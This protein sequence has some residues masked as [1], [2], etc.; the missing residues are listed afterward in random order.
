MVISLLFLFLFLKTPIIMVWLLK[1]AGENACRISLVTVVVYSMYVFS[2][3]GTFI[4]F[5]MLDEYRV[6]IGVVKKDVVF[7]VFLYS[8]ASIICLLLGVIFSRRAL[9]L[10]PIP[11]LSK[12]IKNASSRRMIGLAVALSIICIILYVYVEKLDSV[13]I[14]VAIRG[15]VVDAALARSDMGNNLAGGGA[16]WYSLILSNV[17]PLITYAVFAAWLLKKNKKRLAIFGLALMVSSFIA[18][19]ATEKAPFINLMTSLVMTYYIVRNNGVVSLKKILYFGFVALIILIYFYMIFMGSQ[20]P[21]DAVQSVI[22]RAFSGSITPA[23]FYL[24]YYPNEREYLLG[25]TFPNPG[26]VLPFTPVRYTVDLMNW[27]F[28]ELAASGVVGSMPTIFWAEAFINFGWIGVGFISFFIGVLLSVVLFLISH[29]E[30]NPIT[31]ALNVWLIDHYKKLS[32][33]GFSAHLYDFY[34]WGVVLLIFLLM[35]L[36]GPIKVRRN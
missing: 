6:N 36:T 15:S 26:S 25:Q 13:A 12:D 7:Y 2:V 33:T 18:V 11:V 16:H 14:L 5:F 35:I 23:Y 1:I 28:P 17:G 4:L 19:M 9:K 32:I 21:G 20:T 27:V 8:V 29:L 3:I 30:L 31:V 10:V 34:F 22:S 24:E